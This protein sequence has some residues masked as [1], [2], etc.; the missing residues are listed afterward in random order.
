MTFCISMFILILQFLWKYID[1]LMGKGISIAIILELL[2]YVSASLIP[3]ALPLAILLSSIMTFGNLSEHNELTAL[4]SSGLSLYRIMKPLIVVVIFIATGTFYFSNYVIPVS[5]LKWHSL[6]YDIQNTKISTIIKPGVFSKQL[7]GYAIKVKKEENNTVEDILIYDHTDPNKIKTIRAKKG[8]IYKA[9]NGK[10]IFFELIDGNQSEELNPQ[11]PTFLPNGQ[12]HQNIENYRKATQTAFT[13]STIKID[14]SG[15]SIDKTDEN[16]FKQEYEMLNVFQMKVAIDSIQK[17]ADKTTN[18]FLNSLKNDHL[19]FAAKKFSKDLKNSSLN[20]LIPFDAKE[21]IFD[22]V[23]TNDKILALTNTSIRLRQKNDNLNAQK[24]FMSTIDFSMI[25][26]AVSFHK[27]FALSFAI[28][29]LFFV[30]APLG[31]II[32]KG[33]FGAPVVIAALLFMVYFVLFSVGESLAEEQI[34][35]PFVGMWFATLT[36]TPFAF[37]FMISAANDSPIFNKESYQKVWKAISF[38]KKK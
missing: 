36:L 9:N 16:M 10:Y 18:N 26:F 30:G 38:K 21:I 13:K 37:L 12:I 35:S 6:I 27:K 1:D 28:I 14:L 23:N 32:K 31:A 5:T 2:F 20:K 15:F 22:T 25:Q 8:R 34:V 4:K 29:V 19:F 3:L 33:G 17:N 11:V 24:E 7:D